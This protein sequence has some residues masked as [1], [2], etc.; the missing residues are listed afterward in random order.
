MATDVFAIEGFHESSMNC[1][2]SAAGVTKPVLYQHFESK[3]D[4]YRAVL[5][6]IGADLH[7]TVAKATAE[8]G[9]PRQQIEA[10]F[11]AYFGWVAEN[12]N[13]FHVLFGND[14]RR[15]PE[16]ADEARRVESSIAEI[17]A[18][19]ITVESLP[20]DHRLV[21]GNAIVGMAES[22]CRYWLA[23]DVAVD[24]PTLAADISRLAWAGLR[25]VG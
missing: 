9:G 17:V 13:A 12:S 25:G 8:A 14:T 16:F 2:A 3:R 24:A 20:P 6:E 23:N 19:H 22:A 4:L 11:G 15:D 5:C 10:G 1:I 21:L 7:D 18:H